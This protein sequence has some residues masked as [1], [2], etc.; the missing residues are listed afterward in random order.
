[1]EDDVGPELRH[2][3]IEFG[4]IADVAANIFNGAADLGC[5]KEAGGGA[6]VERVAANLCAELGEPERKPTAL[7]AG[8]AG[9][10]DAAA[11]PDCVCSHGCT[12]SHLFSH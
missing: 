2:G 5:L 3:G 6:G 11:F 9:E 8:V 7:E 12:H 4:G 1:V 10:E